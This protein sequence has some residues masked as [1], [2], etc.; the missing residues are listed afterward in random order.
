MFAQSN[1]NV[2]VV[3]IF[4]TVKGNQATIELAD[5]AT[6]ALKTYFKDTNKVEAIIFNRDSVS[7]QRALLEKRLTEDNISSYS[8]NEEKIKVAKELG[9]DYAAFAEI[10]IKDNSVTLIVWLGSVDNKNWESKGIARANNDNILDLNNSM[11]AAASYAVI[12]IANTAFSE[13]PI[14]NLN[15]PIE[16]G[17]SSAIIT[18]ET[19]PSKPT[20][21]EIAQSAEKKLSEGQLAEAINQYQKAVNEDPSN[22][23]LRIKLSEAFAAKGLFRDA[24]SEL[25]RAIM[26]GADSISVE[27]ARERIKQMENKTIPDS[28]TGPIAEVIMSENNNTSPVEAKNISQEESEKIPKD[29]VLAPNRPSSTTGVNVTTPAVKKMIEGDKLWNDGKPDDAANSYREAIKLNP[30]DWRAYERLAVVNA[31]MGLFGESSNVLA[32]LKK[33]QSSP[34]IPILNNRYIMLRKSFDNHFAEV[35]RQ[36]DRDLLSF[37]KEKISRESYFASLRG[38]IQKLDRMRDFLSS[39]PVPTSQNPANQRRIMATGLV[40]QACFSL[41][42]Y[43]ETNDIDASTNA[44][45]FIRQAKREFETARKLDGNIVLLN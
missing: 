8:P 44:D 23:E 45:L 6:K 12:E 11:Q 32:E 18:S 27:S 22:G 1:N 28:Q 31:S 17:Q 37:N 20:A 40:K 34:D 16:E 43:L 7:V 24:Y 25:G 9:Y 21:E 4:P 26:V 10:S 2:P 38:L 36:Y 41:M 19:A 3:L 13:L 39:I 14:L 29:I 15:R 35:L 5:S 33:I 30:N 42:D